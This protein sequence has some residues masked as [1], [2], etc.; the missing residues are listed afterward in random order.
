[1]SIGNICIIVC[2]VLFISVVSS[3]AL[4]TRP[5]REENRTTHLSNYISLISGVGVI[6][7]LKCPD[8]TEKTFE[9]LARSVTRA[10]N[11]NTLDATLANKATRLWWLLVVVY[12]LGDDLAQSFERLVL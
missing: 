10:V 3:I 1:M 11:S 5:T 8:S 2:K 12:R 6:A 7:L 9:R 4:C